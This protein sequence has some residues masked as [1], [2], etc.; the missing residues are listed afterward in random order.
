M[1]GGLHHLA[2]G[3]VGP[4]AAGLFGALGCLMAIVLM[5]RA[6]RTTG[7][8]RLRLVAYATT[9]IAGPGIWLP[10][11]IGV[12]G[13]EVENSVVRLGA[14]GLALSFAAALGVS[15]AAMLMLC[16][17]RPR[18]VQV[19]G[20]A[21]LLTGALAGT[22]Y[23]MLESVA[24]GGE[25]IYTRSESAVALGA[26]A[27]VAIGLAIAFAFARN[28]RW[29]LVAA[30]GLGLGV[31]A[32]GVLAASTMAVRP[33]AEG[34][35]AADAVVGLAPLQVGV[36]A[37]VLGGVVTAL[38]WYFS[39]GTSTRRDLSVDFGSEPDADHIEPWIIEQ[40]RA[41]VALS[42]TAAPQTAV[43]RPAG[44]SA[45]AQATVAVRSLPVA[46]T[47]IVGAFVGRRAGDAMAYAARP[48]HPAVT[49]DLVTPD[50]VE[51]ASP[52][53]PGP[54]FPAAPVSPAGVP[55]S[56]AVVP[57][58]PDGLHVDADVAA[59]GPASGEGVP[60]NASTIWRRVP[61]WGEPDA[62]RSLLTPRPGDG[63]VTAVPAT[64][65]SRGSADARRQ[66]SWWDQ[67]ERD[68]D[69]EHNEP[70]PGVRGRATNRRH[71][72]PPT[73]TAD[74]GSGAYR[75]VPVVGIDREVQDEAPP[76]LPRRIR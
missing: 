61:G 29:A 28:L 49:A 4:V 26:G 68:Y 39:L 44:S 37:V 34:F 33:W 59:A 64:S 15:A 72:Q 52:V 66:P 75:L 38:L 10:A 55:V 67:R 46:G 1:I 25:V 8:R 2:F 24:T 58:S 22:S 54:A 47:S 9:A 50:R 70:K 32:L 31:S 17:V 12:L 62:S 69:P 65:G 21:L 20:V 7:G 51:L 27:V 16:Y 41:R 30:G 57:V 56:P 73:R 23:L 71:G 35:T 11:L 13:V 53:S 60:W 48:M 19:M 63:A 43:P 74:D 14:I 76:P 6:R 45:W 42:T 40:V 18:A 36:A 3:P 5:A